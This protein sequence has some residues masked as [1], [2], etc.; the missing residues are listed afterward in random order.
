[1]TSP[2]VTVAILTFNG[3]RHLDRLLDAVEDQEYDGPVEILV[4]DSTSTDATPAILARHPNVRVHVIPQ[5]EFGHGKT[6]NLAA[7]LASGEFVAYLTQDAIPLGRTWLAELVAPLIDDERVGGVVGKQ[8]PRDDAPPI[9]RYDI[10]R[11]FSRLGP[12]DAWAVVD[13]RGVDFD[14]P[15]SWTAAFYSDANSATRRSLVVGEV[16]YRDVAYAED[17]LFGRDILRSGRR[18]V[19]APAASVEHSNDLTMR[20]VGARIDD[21]VTGLRAIGAPVPRLSRAGVVKQAVRWSLA[22]AAAIALDRDWGIA[23]KARW[24]LANPWWHVRKW[25]AFRRASTRDT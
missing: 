3:E 13:G 4:I 14:G 24:L 23:R 2:A 22:D 7:T 19:Y 11:V 1:V 25:R 6:R 5:S 12:D 18:K 20:T 16:P 21:E 9:I 8:V 10:R 15:D 17:Q